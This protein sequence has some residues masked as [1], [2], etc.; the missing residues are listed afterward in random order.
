MSHDFVFF[1]SSLEY[2]ICKRRSQ[3]GSVCKFHRRCFYSWI[4]FMCMSS[5][6]HEKTGSFKKQIFFLLSAQASKHNL[7]P[8]RSH[9]TSE[10]W[11]PCGVEKRGVQK[12]KPSLWI[13]VKDEESSKIAFKNLSLNLFTPGLDLLSISDGHSAVRANHLQL[14][15]YLTNI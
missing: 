1:F 6:K 9:K 2:H 5:N 12:S 8:A 11:F 15:G 14:H 10:I 7:L 4:E 13:S 3:R